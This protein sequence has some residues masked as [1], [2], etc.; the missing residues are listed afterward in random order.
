MAKVI[1]PEEHRLEV[2]KMY[3][4]YKKGVSQP[5]F[6]YRF[7]DG[8]AM[9]P[10]NMQKLRL[11]ADILGA[12]IVDQRGLKNVPPKTFQIS[13]G[14]SFRDYQVEPSGSLLES[15]QKNKY[16]TFSAPCGTGKTLMLTF[17]SGS[18]GE[19][20]L[21]LVDQTNLMANWIEANQ[22]MWNRPVQIIDGKTKDLGHVGIT[23]FQLLHRNEELLYRLK[24][25]YGCLL[26][27]EA[28]TC[29]ATT[30][31][32]VIQRLDNRYRIATS[33]TFF[34][35]HFPTELLVDCCGA[36]VCVTM[37]DENALIPRVDFVS[38]YVDTPSDIP[39]DFGSKTL[40][41]L[42]SND[43]RNALIVELVRDGISKGRHIVVICIK[44]DQARYLADKCN[45][46]CNAETY[47]GTSSAKKDLDIKTR[48]ESGK[49]D[50]VFTCKKLDKGTDFTVADMIIF[51][52]PGN[53][54]SMVQ[55]LSGRVVR[56][57]EGKPEPIIVDLVDR[58]QL[59]WRFAK[60]RYK[61]YKNLN[62]VFVK[63]NYFFLDM[64]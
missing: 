45:E 59:V 37:K 21:I 38:T 19:S 25:H 36:P 57:K 53:N 44:Q 3:T 7:K 34:N 9:L 41:Y 60:N 51:T 43:K 13:P 50:C 40:P 32:K 20:T 46:F 47:V 49:I 18:L 27:D 15:I 61:W 12:T 48:F 63:D 17:V 33:A 58:G 30:F 22:L 5:V 64:F 2:L 55:Q 42:A 26:I 24:D 28:H 62:Y 11:V 31:T 14:F 54:E 56:K 8:I 39:D 52:R 10:L 4:Y 23:T 6:S 35:K 1:L 29:Q 16:G